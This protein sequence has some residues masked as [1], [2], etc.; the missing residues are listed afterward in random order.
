MAMN[1]IT[2]DVAEAQ[3]PNTLP[4]AA[5]WLEQR[6]RMIRSKRLRQEDVLEKVL[7]PLKT[8]P[9]ILG[10][11]L[12][13]SVAS[14]TH[15]W[16]SDLDMLF[17]YRRH[18]PTSGLVTNYMDSIEVQL[19]FTTLET[20]IYNVETVPYLLFMFGKGKI[21]LDRHGSITPV[22]RQITRY[23]EAHPDVAE[24]WVRITQLHQV[25]KRGPLCAQTTIIQRWDELE[26]KYS[27]GARKRTFF[28]LNEEPDK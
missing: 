27:G 20:L 5:L 18:E 21:L 4:L 25:E 13:G 6:Y 8:D 15:T 16:K 19:F 24:E 9:N 1:M 2:E 23:Y 12:F 22:I 26:E 14:G 28:L 11:L 17:V 3:P 7:S 10:I